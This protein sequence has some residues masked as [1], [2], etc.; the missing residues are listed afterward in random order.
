MSR[1]ETPPGTHPAPKLGATSVPLDPSVPEALYF[2]YGYRPSGERAVRIDMLERLAQEIRRAREGA[3]RQGFE[4]TQRMQSLLGVSGEPFESVLKSLGYKKDT[5]T[6][7]VPAEP[8][9]EAAS[10]E[11]PVDP[12]AASPGAASGAEGGTIAPAPDA[13]APDALASDAPPSEPTAR[14]EPSEDGPSGDGAERASGAAAAEASGQDAP[15]EPATETVTLWRWAP[16]QRGRGPRSKGSGRPG[17]KPQ[18]QRG[19]KGARGKGGPPRGK[20]GKGGGKPQGPRTFS[21]GPPKKD[22]AIDPD[23]PFAALAALKED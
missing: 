16:P 19:P 3:G 5:V 6:R 23:N 2:A 10:G 8:G 4:A 13:L 17:G 7:E 12:V 20:G 21:S 1:T 15:A 14:V 18:D 22:R 11:R 9:P